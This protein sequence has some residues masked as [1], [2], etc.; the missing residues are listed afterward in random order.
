MGGL[1]LAKIGRDRYLRLVRPYLLT[2][3]VVVCAFIGISAAVS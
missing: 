3:F 2:F 1:A